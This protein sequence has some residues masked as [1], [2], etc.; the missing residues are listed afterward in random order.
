MQGSDP[1]LSRPSRRRKVA[2]LNEEQKQRKRN[3]DRQAQQAFRERT[4]AQIHDLKEKVETLH[5]QAS[6]NGDTWRHENA[7]LRKQVQRLSQRLREIRDLTGDLTE[8]MLDLEHNR[9]LIDSAAQTVHPATNATSPESIIDAVRD[10]AA[11]ELLAADRPLSDATLDVV[12]HR[13]ND[14]GPGAPQI[15]SAT[16]RYASCLQNVN[17]DSPL[18]SAMDVASSVSQN[19]APHMNRGIEPSDDR[20]HV[21][22]AYET[23]NAGSILPAFL[24]PTPHSAQSIPPCVPPP[25]TTLRRE[26]YETTC[27]HSHRTCPFDHILVNHVELKRADIARGQSIS[28]AIG[29]LEPDIAGIFQPEKAAR[30]HEL[31]RMLVEMML[32]FAHVNRPERIAFMYK[33][34]K[35]MRVS[36][37]SFDLRA[38]F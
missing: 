17:Q 34:H 14:E 31:S 23:I 13:H 38:C 28:S 24:P 3:M 35:T 33:I 8:P 12:K 10:N 37:I 29:P 19:E 18:N 26:V 9:M 16:Q 4:K 2:D 6:E 15:P 11:D 21:A 1:T 30:S 27:D 36:Q 5:R 22:T 7:R 20:S 32:T 25:I